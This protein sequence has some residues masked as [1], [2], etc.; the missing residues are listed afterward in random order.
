VNCACGRYLTIHKHELNG[1][2][3]VANQIPQPHYTVILHLLDPSHWVFTIE[4]YEYM[5]LCTC[6]VWCLKG[7]CLLR[8]TIV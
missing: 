5:H 4:N 8:V 2:P 7:L 1:M 3:N 6:I